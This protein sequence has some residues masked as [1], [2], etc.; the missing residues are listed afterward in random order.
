MKEKK[1]TI[2]N[3][4]IKQQGYS[5]ESSLR[6]ENK[7]KHKRLLE[8]RYQEVVRIP[9]LDGRKKLRNASEP[10]EELGPEEDHAY[11]VFV[12]A[13]AVGLHSPQGALVQGLAQ[14]TCQDA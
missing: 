9:V 6:S 4:F 3:G 5:Y 10:A 11:W 2:H 12:S 8:K 7:Y 1:D 13:E 14:E